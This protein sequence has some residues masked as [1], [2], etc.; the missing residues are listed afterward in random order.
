MKKFIVAIGALVALSACCNGG[1]EAITIDEQNHLNEAY[2]LSY[3]L[4]TAV[5]EAKDY[6]EF[7]VASDNLKAHK[8]AFR[9][10]IGGESYQIFLEETNLI[11][12]E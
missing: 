8:G 12:A 1:S 10:Q 3:D 9:K 5:V 11:L 4:A 6:E 7:K 2:N